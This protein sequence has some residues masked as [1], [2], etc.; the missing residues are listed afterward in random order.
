MH[1]QAV[2][3]LNAKGFHYKEKIFSF[4]SSFVCFASVCVRW[5]MLAGPLATI[6]SLTWQDVNPAV[7]SCFVNL[8]SDVCQLFLNETGKNW[9][10]YNKESVRAP[11]KATVTQMGETLPLD[12]WGPSHSTH[13]CKG[14][15]GE[16]WA[17]HFLCLSIPSFLFS[18]YLFSRS[19]EIPMEIKSSFSKRRPPLWSFETQIFFKRSVG[20]ISR[21]AR[22]QCGGSGA[23][24]GIP[25]LPWSSTFPAGTP[26]FTTAPTHATPLVCVINW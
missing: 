10:N 3:R 22:G 9:K 16:S 20:R 15:W 4:L 11:L 13:Q 26:Y 7:L 23:D 17:G 14:M 6:T 12:A 18:Y 1:R 25:P 19:N 5:W 24:Q 2:K 8:C 21:L